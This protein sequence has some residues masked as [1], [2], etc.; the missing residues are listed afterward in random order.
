MHSVTPH[1]VC[2]GAADAIAFY[3]RA[4]GAVETA[5]LPGKDGKL[6]HAA[7]RIGDSSVMLVD[8]MP[9]WNSVGPKSLKGTAVT[10]HLY[11][12]DVDAIAARAVAA[13][14]TVI[15]PVAD[16]FWG[17]RYGVLEDPFGHRW[18]IATHI[19]D[20]TPGE[21]QEAMR[22]MAAEPPHKPG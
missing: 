1:L 18:S 15:M 6:M 12:D 14:A 10:I 21:M 19:R 17:D 20:V 5:R 2:A 9:E 7:V 8:E 4:F 22:K 11:V 16:M 3:T 13:G